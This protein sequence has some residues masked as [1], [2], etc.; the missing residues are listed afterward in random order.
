ML[1]CWGAWFRHLTLALSRVEAERGA[2]GTSEAPCAVG[3]PG[4]ERDGPGKLEAAGDK[5]KTDSG[6]SR[7]G[8]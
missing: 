4:S 5:L 8:N 6:Q 3:Q 2:A 7:A 1:K